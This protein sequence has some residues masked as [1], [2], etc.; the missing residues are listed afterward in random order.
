MGITE[1]TRFAQARR[2][3]NTR[4]RAMLADYK[5]RRN[6][7]PEAPKF[8]EQL[9]VDPHEIVKAGKIASSKQSGRVID[10]WPDGALSPL[11]ESSSIKACL[12]HWRDGLAWDQT[13]IIAQMLKAIE[14]NGKV[15][16]LRNEDDLRVRYEELDN[17]FIETKKEMRL[18]TRAELVPGNFREEGGI[19]VH[20]SPDGEPVFGK[21][22]HHRLAM[23]LALGLTRIPV[24]VG[25]VHRDAIAS[26]HKYRTEAES[27]H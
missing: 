22:G 20:I 24:Q 9:W 4:R 5:N 13:G 12:Q 6:F 15:D 26:L 2:N 1:K 14:R 8:A 21:K 18:K 27:I 17:I 23:A 7:G 10:T 16:R 3:W 19:L 11:M 25:A